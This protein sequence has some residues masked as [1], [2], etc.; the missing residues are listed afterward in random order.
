MILETNRD[1]VW[2]E[3]GRVVAT[4]GFSSAWFGLSCHYTSTRSTLFWFMD[5]LTEGA[6]FRDTV[7]SRVETWEVV[8]ARTV[9]LGFSREIRVE[10]FDKNAFYWLDG[11]PAIDSVSWMDPVHVH[12][13]LAEDYPNG[14]LLEAGLQSVLGANGGP[15]EGAAFT[16]YFYKTQ[17]YDLV[18][19]EVMA[20]PSP[21]MGLPGTSYLE[22]FNR[23]E[24]PIPVSGFTLEVGSRRA[25]LKEGV[26]YPG[27]YLLLV[28]S[29]QATLWSFVE[30]VL[31][32]TDWSQLPVSGA[33]MVLR[34]NFG[35]VV[36]ACHYRRDMGQEGFKRDGGWS[37]EV[38]DV[39]NLSGHP[40][41]WDYSI[42]NVGGT[43]GRPN[44]LSTQ[45][46]DET[47]PRIESVY[48]KS[49]SC[50]VFQMTEPMGSDFLSDLEDAWFLPGGLSV[51]SARLTEPFH[52][53]LEVC[54]THK[55]PQ[56]RGCEMTFRKM[57]ADLAGNTLVTHGP[58]RFAR[59][60]VAQPFDVVINELLYDPPAGGSDFVELYNRSDKHIDLSGLFLSRSNE[61]G[62]P[63]TLVPLSTVKRA[64]F[65]GEYLVLTGDREGLMATYNVPEALGIVLTEGMPN[66]V[67]AGGT[68]VLSDKKAS[69]IDAFTYSEALHYPLLST[70]KGVSL[71]RMDADAPTQQEF[72][73]HSASA[74]E[75]YATPGRENSQSLPPKGSTAPDFISLEPGVFTPNQ[76]GID[77]LLR[78]SYAFEKPGYSCSVTIYN[79][80]GQPVRY[81][82]NNELAGTSGFF[83]WDGLN[84]QNARCSTGI[85]VL[86]VRCFHPS[87]AVK[88]AKKVTVLST[89]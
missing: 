48:L 65:P 81:L 16:L 25:I 82:V 9:R 69:V 5:F 26:L 1:G 68:V 2:Q 44:S 10:T 17:R 18:F 70:T 72:N 88:E 13:H 37:L 79:R 27:E 66:Y 67:V 59:P 83:S 33:E 19:S 64:L 6:A 30:N 76:D 35:D 87:G 29:G 71:E 12:I 74:D 85:Y 45:L 28:P 21:S 62:L 77:D 51:Q 34:D 43:P 80:A 42:D 58:V 78:I 3:E 23:S 84:E 7:P 38:R 40:T 14:R 75:G 8:D 31:E 46:P 41:N 20:D 50:V 63:E 39:H 47:A 22:I 55:L 36:A 53:G 32:L 60:L 15:V 4:E 89:H 73:W 49:D 86:L 61:A 24:Q 56:N 52:S 11:G 57:P 54:F